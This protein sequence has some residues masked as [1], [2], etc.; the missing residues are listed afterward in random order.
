[1]ITTLSQLIAQAESN[2]RASAVRFEPAFKPSELAIQ[3]CMKANNCNH[4]T[5]AV[6]C[7]MSFGKYQMMGENIYGGWGFGD[8][9]AVFMNVDAYQDAGFA[10]Y[11]N[12]R[13]INYTLS[14][15]VNNQL[16]RETFGKKYN[17]NGPVYA[18]YLMQVFKDTNHADA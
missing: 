12:T 6:I 15:M 18:V 9:I 17:G 2:N 13:D 8:P 11:V 1:M 10:W 16:T 14:D 5:A 4:S 3:K 7:A